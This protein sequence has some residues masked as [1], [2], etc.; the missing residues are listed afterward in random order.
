MLTK[1]QYVALNACADDW[2][3]FYFPFAMVNYGGQ[4][5]A[6]AAGPG[7][8][9]YD[10]ERAWSIHV[11]AEQI[12][13][14]LATLV[15]E[16]FLEARVVGT[17]GDRHGVRPNQV[18]FSQYRGYD[19]LTFDDHVARLGYGPHEFLITEKGLSEIDNPSYRAYDKELGWPT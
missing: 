13:E 19:C 11:P 7:F 10:D 8:Y 18:E 1:T 16:G 15:R 6:R 12:A 9:Q 17:S 4:V 3:I 2:E 5:F 14:A